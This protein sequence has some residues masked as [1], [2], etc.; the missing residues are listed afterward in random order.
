VNFDGQQRERQEQRTRELGD[1]SF[2][3]RGESFVFIPNVGYDVLRRV[4]ELGGDSSGEDVVTTLED[5]VLEMIEEDDNAH[6][7]F[8][9]LRGLKEF[10]VTFA[11]LN[12]IAAWLIGQQVGRPTQAPSSSTDGRDATGTTST[13]GSSPVP[14]V[15]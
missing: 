13:D 11:D 10:P 6:E 1:R 12:D 14:A 8:R 9:A 5:A 7:R 15:A 3:L 4:A 2:T